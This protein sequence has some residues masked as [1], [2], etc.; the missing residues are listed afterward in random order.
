MSKNQFLK[1]LKRKLSHLSKSELDERIN[2]YSEM[3]DDRI[4][5]GLSEKEAVKAIGSAD[6]I[7]R[8]IAEELKQGNKNY[9]YS[10]SKKGNAKK[11][12]S[13]WVIALLIIGSPIWL[14]I[15]IAVAAVILSLFIAVWSVIISLWAVF[16]SLVG[17]GAGIAIA[18]IYLL[19]NVKA[20]TGI[21]FI[22]AGIACLGLSILFFFACKAL[23]SA[24]VILTKKLFLSIFMK[25]KGDR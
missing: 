3:I 23:T 12:M 5:S 17:A 16:G 9:E 19:I 15:L 22:C 6:M 18:G 14:S 13:P 10:K 25:K 2:F 7:A 20:V 1:I 24:A 8:Q 4:E 21:A 11:G